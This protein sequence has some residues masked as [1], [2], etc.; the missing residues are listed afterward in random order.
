MQRGYT[1]W[2]LLG[3]SLVGLLLAVYGVLSTLSHSWIPDLIATPK[4]MCYVGLWS[5]IFLIVSWLCIEVPYQG[6][7]LADLKRLIMSERR[8]RQQ[9]QASYHEHECLALSQQKL[10]QERDH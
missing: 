10:L 2:S 4:W 9:L 7:H 3:V 1:R 8:L 6:R 5:L